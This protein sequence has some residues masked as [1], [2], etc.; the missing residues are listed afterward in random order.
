MR[1][2][3]SS[4]TCDYTTAQLHCDLAHLACLLQRFSRHH[5]VYEV[6]HHFIRVELADS[7]RD[8][9]EQDGDIACVVSTDAVFSEQTC[10][11]T[12]E[13]LCEASFRHHANA[14]SL[15]WC[16]EGRGNHLRATSRAKVYGLAVFQ[17]LLTAA[18][19]VDGMFL[20]KLV[21]TK[22]R[23]T[24]NQVAYSCWSKPC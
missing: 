9:L 17:R 12:N 7:I 2:H 3:S 6:V 20:K 23:A 4:D 21:T 5:R 8:L 14:C 24:L 13:T 19:P 16:Q 22:L 10:Q 1:E 15:Q 18:Q 11:R